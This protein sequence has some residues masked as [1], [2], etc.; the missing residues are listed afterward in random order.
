MKT[1]ITSISL[2][3][4]MAGGAAAVEING[5]IETVDVGKGTVVISGV[6]ISAGE[7]ILKNNTDEPITIHDLKPG[8]RVEVKGT[9]VRPRQMQAIEIEKDPGG[10][11]GV[12]GRI[13]EVA[14]T[15]KSLVIG[16]ITVKVLMDTVFKDELNKVIQFDRFAAGSMVT[17]DGGWTGPGQVTAKKVQLD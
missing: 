8:D 3:L 12:E 14:S 13:S 9:S 4:F 16:G 11:D 2:F 1:F 15:E 7:A 5:K 6:T 17:C 10:R